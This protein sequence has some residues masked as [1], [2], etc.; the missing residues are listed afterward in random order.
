MLHK[1]YKQTPEHRE[2]SG[3]ALRGRKLS[4]EH[5]AKISAAM[6]GNQ[7]GLG[8]VRSKEVRA[9]TATANRLRKASPETRAK[10]S[11]SRLGPKHPNWKGGRILSS[12]GYVLIYRP[13]HPFADGGGYVKEHRLIVEKA[14]GRYL[15]PSEKVH[16]D[17][18]DRADNRNKNLVAC[19]DQNYHRLLH[20]RAKALAAASAVGGCP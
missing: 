7:Y 1:G 2:H 15:K 13:D 5:C 20:R 19:Q 17:N 11:A 3:A 16:H 4:P 6:M 18:E 10:I 14:I 12:A 8:A 9:K